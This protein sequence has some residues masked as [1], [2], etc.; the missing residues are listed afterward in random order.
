MRILS[1]SEVSDISG[2]N[3]LTTG[4]SFGA[5]AGAFWGVMGGSTSSLI[6]GGFTGAGALV[7]AAGGAGWMVGTFIH[8]RLVSAYPTI[9]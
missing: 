2:G 1:V 9:F 3:A 6:L 5:G 7:G 8:N 4:M